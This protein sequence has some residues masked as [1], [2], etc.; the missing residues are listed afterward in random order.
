[1]KN[2]ILTIL[3][4]G[5]SSDEYLINMPFFNMLVIIYTSPTL[6]EKKSILKQAWINKIRRSDNLIH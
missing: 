5:G 1:M 4:R 3:N 2:N 6:F